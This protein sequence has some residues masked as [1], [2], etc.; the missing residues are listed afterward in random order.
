MFKEKTIE[1]SK[2]LSHISI[3]LKELIRT[4]ESPQSENGDIEDWDSDLSSLLLLVYLLPPTSQGRRKPG[5]LSATHAIEHL[6]RFLKTGNSVQGHLDAIVQTCQPASVCRG[7]SR[8][9]A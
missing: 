7:W 8:K 5:R 2:T 1:Q 9:F 4:A 3:E 6:V